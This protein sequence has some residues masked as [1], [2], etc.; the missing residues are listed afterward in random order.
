VVAVL[1]AWVEVVLLPL[2]PELP[3]RLKPPAAVLWAQAA[4][5]GS[6]TARTSTRMLVIRIA[7]SSG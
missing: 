5:A 4:P 3:G 2:L 6:T 7:T 1:V